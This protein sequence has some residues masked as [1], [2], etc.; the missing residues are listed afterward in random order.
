M[1]RDPSHSELRESLCGPIDRG[2]LRRWHISFSRWIFDYVFNPLQLAL[3]DLRT[4]GVVI[5]LMV[6]FPFPAIWHGVGLTF[7]VWG[8]IHGLYMSV[9]IDQ[10][11]FES[12]WHDRSLARPSPRLGTR[13]AGVRNC[14][15]RGV[16]GSFF[17]H[18]SLSRRAVRSHPSGDRRFRNSCAAVHPATTICSSSVPAAR[19]WGGLIWSVAASVSSLFWCNP[20]GRDG[21]FDHAL[22]AAILIFGAEA[23]TAFI[24]FQF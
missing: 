4:A 22:A 7:V 18:E 1:F 12:K 19:S 5:A 10:D 20:P 6:T 24:Y 17:E 11:R 14:T 9:S 15:S 8:L 13:V 2:V 23:R 16:Y 3:R 21:R